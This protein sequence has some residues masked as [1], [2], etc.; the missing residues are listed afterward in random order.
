MYLPTLKSE[1]IHAPTTPNFPVVCPLF[2]NFS[3]P[4]SDVSWKR[5]HPEPHAKIIMLRELI[6]K[7]YYN[8]VALLFIFANEKNSEHLRRQ[9]LAMR[10]FYQVD[11]IIFCRHML[12]WNALISAILPMMAGIW[13]PPNN[14]LACD[15]TNKVITSYER[16]LKNIWQ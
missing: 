12:P 1:K 2:F 14:K 5:L 16:S 4:F 3:L 15:I 10:E 11:C 9:E 7:L 8:F 6:N 13:T